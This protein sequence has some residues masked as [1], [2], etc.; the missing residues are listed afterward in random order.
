M[1][2]ELKVF[3]ERLSIEAAEGDIGVEVCLRLG[4]TD[5]LVLERQLIFELGSDGGICKYFL[6]YKNNYTDVMNVHGINQLSSQ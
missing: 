3:F 5:W 4:G 2:A 6:S 1:L